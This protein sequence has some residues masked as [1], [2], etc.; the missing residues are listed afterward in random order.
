MASA[1]ADAD[2]AAMARL[3]PAAG[4]PHRKVMVRDVDKAPV[5]ETRVAAAVELRRRWQSNR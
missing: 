4:K 3:L 2:E 1:V 5:A